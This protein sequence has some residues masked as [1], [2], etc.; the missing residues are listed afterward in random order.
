LKNELDKNADPTFC[1]ILPNEIYNG[2]FTNQ[3]VKAS[4]YKDETLEYEIII[5]IHIY[6]NLYGLGLLNS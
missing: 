3:Y 5:P 2:E 4:I 1:S 6:L